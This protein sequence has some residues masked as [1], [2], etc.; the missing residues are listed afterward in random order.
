MRH[1]LKSPVARRLAIA[2]SIVCASSSALAASDE[3]E[4]WTA[5]FQGTYIWQTKPGMPAAYSGPNSLQASREISYTAT[6][7]AFMT[8][9]PG[10]TT[11]PSA[12]P[13]T[14]PARSAT[15][16]AATTWART[17]YA[18]PSP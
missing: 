16:A 1:C 11:V 5:R 3:Y 12:A 14:T 8:V 2:L 4:D 6:A 15:P 10:G 17:R 13:A 9:A 7:T 18:R